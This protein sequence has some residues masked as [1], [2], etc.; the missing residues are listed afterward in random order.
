[1]TTLEL[2]AVPLVEQG[3]ARAD[4]R[5]TT[6]QQLQALLGDD[7]GEVESVAPEPGERTLQQDY[8]DEYAAVRAKE[9]AELANGIS[10]PLP[11]HA[12]G[13][14]STVDAY[15]SASR[16]STSP[17]DPRGREQFQRAELTIS[18]AGTRASHWRETCTS[19]VQVDHPFG[20]TQTAEV[21]VPA[22]ASKVRWYNP[23]TGAREAVT[24]RATRVGKNRNVDVLHASDSTYYQP[25]N[26]LFPKAIYDIPYGEI[27]W[28][29]PRVWDGRGNAN[30][31]DANGRTQWQKVFSTD[32]VFTGKLYI[33][34]GLVRVIFDEP[35]N[36]LTVEEWDTGTSSWTTV[37]QG[38]SDWELFDVDLR[39]LGL[40]YVRARVEFR[41]PTA[42]PTAYYRLSMRLGRGVTRPIWGN[43][44]ESGTPVPS[45]LQTKLDP[46]ASAN[47]RD[48]Q[49]EM[50]ILSRREVT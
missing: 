5:R 39:R 31:E 1:M 47:I 14:T 7:V 22:A 46:V 17:I 8:V 41:D 27:G 50:G 32:H 28:T 20:T 42:S 16:A 33:E 10:Q 36:S 25:G 13:T 23:R 45:G 6:R 29:D 15:V 35:A 12:T 48:A 19:V 34:N 37:S 11:L 49:V 3:Q 21:G 40:G 43:D 38:A 2:Y 30:K 18:E 24:V 26:N 9:L 4:R 44:V